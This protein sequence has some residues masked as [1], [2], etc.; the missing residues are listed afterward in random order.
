MDFGA[1][2]NLDLRGLRCP[3]VVRLVAREASRAGVWRLEVL[4]NDP[5]MELDLR[6]WAEGAGWRVEA[7]TN[8]DSATT[9]GAG[10]QLMLVRVEAP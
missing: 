10:V 9:P 7:V 2:L 1:P 4:G 6:A 8:L 5:A 3:L